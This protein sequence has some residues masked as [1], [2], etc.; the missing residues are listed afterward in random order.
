MTKEQIDEAS[1]LELILRLHL[2]HAVSNSRPK[3]A[4]VPIR[5]I[6]EAGNIVSALKERLAQIQIFRAHDGGL[7]GN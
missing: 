4:G 1:V 3:C 6:Q 5:D 7:H 2:L